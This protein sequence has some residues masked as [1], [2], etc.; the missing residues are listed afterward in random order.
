MCDRFLSTHGDSLDSPPPP[1]TLIEW[2]VT[3]VVSRPRPRLE[4]T[5]TSFSLLHLPSTM[6]NDNTSRLL[7]SR[8]NVFV[9][10]YRK[11]ILVY[12]YIYSQPY[13]RTT[14]K[15][16][17]A[18]DSKPS[19]RIVFQLFD[20]KVPKTARNFR[21]LATGQHGFGYAGSPF[22]RVIPKVCL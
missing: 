12:I 11:H 9:S 20:D 16:D 19:G 10:D 22:H 17:I 4:K 8:S 1:S 13:S 7:L 3:C 21:E 18:I 6:L 2:P 14:Q 5:C 15:F